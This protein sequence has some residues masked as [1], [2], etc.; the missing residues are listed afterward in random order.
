M[1]TYM[2]SIA[3][4]QASADA[5]IQG[6]MQLQAFKGFIAEEGTLPP[7]W[8]QTTQFETTLS[9]KW[10]DNYIGYR[11]SWNPA[12]MAWVPVQSLDTCSTR[13]GD[14]VL[15]SDKTGTRN[16]QGWGT[17]GAISLRN[18]GRPS[19]GGFAQVHSGYQPATHQ[20]PPAV[21]VAALPPTAEKSFT[22]YEKLVLTL[23]AT[24]LD[25]YAIV[26]QISTQSVSIDFSEITS[27][28]VFYDI[29]QGWYSR[30]HN[31]QVN[32]DPINLAAELN[33]RK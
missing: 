25:T 3:M 13:P 24:H 17:P 11:T 23:S 14:Q 4:S 22:P 8:F 27:G 16:M 1:T 9:V 18:D 21:C 7:L 5:L 26:E 29:N 6:N 20:M 19:W 12:T 31:V 10:D 15:F 28:H 2:V 30:D 33:M 32:N